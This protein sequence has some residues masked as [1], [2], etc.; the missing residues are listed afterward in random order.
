[1]TPLTLTHAAAFTSFLAQGHLSDRTRRSYDSTLRPFVQQHAF[2]LVDQVTLDELERYLDSLVLAASTLN[3][4]RV[5][6]R[7]F[8][9]YTKRKGWRRDNPALGLRSIKPVR[10][11]GEHRTDEVFRYYTDNEVRALLKTAGGSPRLSAVIH[12][13]YESGARIDEIL[14]LHK[15]S[16]DRHR[17]RFRVIGKGNKARWCY[18]GELA[19]KAL[20]LYIER[21][22]RPHEALF[23]HRHHTKR[24]VLAAT[25][26]HLA[27]EWRTTFRGTPF[28]NEVGFHRIR[29][30]FATVRLSTDMPLPVLQALLGHEQIATTLRYAKVTSEKAEGDARKALK[31]LSKPESS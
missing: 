8:Y 27:Y 23:T 21:R 13:I 30:T 15:Q 17:L 3:R 4:Y 31:K 22:Q 2:R 26:D 20:A 28:A 25:Y 19:E 6:L 1:M 16:L 11:R 29:H 24:N 12:L 10:E 9:E 7:C 18:F 5:T 14:T